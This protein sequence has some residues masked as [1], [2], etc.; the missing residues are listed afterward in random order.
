VFIG[1]YDLSGSYSIPGQIQ[2]PVVKQACQ[3]VVNACSRAGKSVGLLMARPTLES[4]QQAI[5]DGYT[6]LCL[7]VDVVFLS[8]RAQAT[9]ALA[10]EALEKISH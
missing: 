9:R 1:P 5:D 4:V 10:L 8:E 3:L 6:L 2:A 7:G